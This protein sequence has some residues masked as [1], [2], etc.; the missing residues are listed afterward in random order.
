MT[1]GTKIF[2]IAFL[3]LGSKPIY[4]QVHSVKDTNVLDAIYVQ[5]K[6]PPPPPYQ[7]H[8]LT[9][10]LDTIY[11]QKNKP[12][13]KRPYWILKD[14]LPNDGEWNIYRD[15]KLLCRGY[16]KNGVRNGLFIEY[17]SLLNINSSKREEKKGKNYPFEITEYKKGYLD[18]IYIKYHFNPYGI[19]CIGQYKNGNAV[20]MWRY[21][22]DNDKFKKENLY[23]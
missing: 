21:Y 2:I 12:P 23:K 20:G 15:G 19:S 1:R 10:G 9:Y 13:Y 8:N 11:M 3:L 5:K 22:D 6:V 4:S 14:T 16:Y 18:G 17:K 7:V